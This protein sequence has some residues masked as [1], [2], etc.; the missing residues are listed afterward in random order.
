[1][2]FIY[3]NWI[4]YFILCIYLYITSYVFGRLFSRLF[5][6][7]LND[8]L[9]LSFGFS[10][11]G[12]AVPLALSAILSFKDIGLI[13][14]SVFFMLLYFYRDIN[15]KK[16]MKQIVLLLICLLIFMLP[17]ASRKKAGIFTEFGG[18][19]GIYMNWAKDVPDDSCF[20][21]DKF[22]NFSVFYSRIS[23]G[24]V[25]A[26]NAPKFDLKSFYDNTYS[27][28]GEYE[29]KLMEDTRN[30]KGLNLKMGSVLNPPYNWEFERTHYVCSRYSEFTGWILP[31]GYIH[32]L[33]SFFHI[34]LVYFSVLS[35]IYY[36]YISLFAEF[37]IW[38]TKSKW[39]QFFAI[40]LILSS[41]SFIYPAYNHYFPAWITGLLYF[42]S[43]ILL[44]SDLHK[45]DKLTC[46][47]LQIF[48]SL[49]ILS[50]YYP[51]SPFHGI[52]VLIY[53]LFYFRDFNLKSV[54]ILTVVFFT[55]VSFFLIPLVFH[56]I[57]YLLHF[58]IGNVIEKSSLEIM[59]TNLGVPIPFFSLTAF[60]AGL[61]FIQHGHIPPYSNDYLSTKFL[62]TVFRIGAVS[63]FVLLGF[64]LSYL[65]RQK[66]FKIFLLLIFGYL[67]FILSSQW[68]A[69]TQFKAFSYAMTIVFLLPL[70]SVR[71]ASNW[72]E[73]K[74]VFVLISVY[75]ISMLFY[76]VNIMN[77]M[78]NE[79]SRES[80]I[81]LTDFDSV[82]E[83]NDQENIYIFEPHNVSAVFILETLINEVKHLYA[84]EYSYFTRF[85]IS[86]AEI[87]NYFGIEK[88]R[89]IFRENGKWKRRSLISIL[90]EEGIVF[91]APLYFKQQNY[92]ADAEIF[93]EGN[94]I[95]RLVIKP[96]VNPGKCITPKAAKWNQTGGKFDSLSHIK[97]DIEKCEYEY[98]I[99]ANS[100]INSII[101]PGR[102]YISYK[103]LK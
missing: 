21:R 79:K 60:K 2:D 95:M 47:L 77:S 44:F 84:R 88:F 18:D 68:S 20:A 13:H 5:N 70:I 52:F 83:K 9:S 59:L 61:G 54:K 22:T 78:I 25:S 46:F 53:L 33:F 32:K 34:A 100:G 7:K 12:F 91:L 6:G 65:I 36:L 15:L 51:Y 63:Y 103:F 87:I 74:A 10:I 89:Y 16:I 90:K 98:S 102:N 76:R 67:S 24:A 19:I 43:L 55:A 73:R 30:A 72:I 45:T 80:I 49:I 42:Q 66:Q 94:Q 93:F 37:V 35:F 101:V 85:G 1:M 86:Y 56:G 41:H 23:E 64:S 75:I 3:T 4:A 17:A 26:F 28:V 58:I 62:N 99:V 40:L 57:I 97:V 82:I 11:F 96:D 29:A 92:A 8:S 31:Q 50:F 38:K 81:S 69:Y 27:K 39:N 71:F 48:I 14:C